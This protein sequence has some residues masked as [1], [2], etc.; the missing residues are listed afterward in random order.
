MIN[1]NNLGLKIKTRHGFETFK[2]IQKLEKG[3]WL[4]LHLEGR[5]IEVTPNHRLMTTEGWKECG[6]MII[7]DILKTDDYFEEVTHIEKFESDKD[8]YDILETESH[9]FI[10][11][12]IV[13][14]NCRFQGSSG[15]LIPSN[16]LETLEWTNPIN[17]DDYLSIYEEPKINNR[18]VAIADPAGGFGLDY[19]VC[20]IIDV[21]D[22]PYK[23]VAKYRNNEISP[24]IF[25]HTI[26]NMCMTYNNCPALVEANNDVGG[27]VTYIL[28]YELEYEN[29][30][31]TSSSQRSIGEI[32][33][34]GK[35][36]TTVPG[37]KT[38]KKVKSVGCSNLKA[39]LENQYL[40]IPDQ[41]MIEELGTFVI[42]GSGYEADEDC[43]DDTVMTLILFSWF[44]KQEFFNDY[45]SSNLGSDIYD[46][47]V[48]RA[49]EDVLPFGHISTSENE[50]QMMSENH[51]ISGERMTV[52]ENLHKSFD[53]W[54]ME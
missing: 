36:S 31:L 40:L 22:Y 44:V 7:G 10:V 34:G 5:T 49:M 16:I 39:L 3:V 23:I 41:D 6:D 30:V 15:T 13:S 8:V 32:R 52:T 43:Y 45:T 26:M 42:K 14:H 33:V 48:K 11:N 46:R 28:Y 9:E 35:G 24:M 50:T 25:P 27:Q 21:T 29:V 37:V 2:G 38:T 18:Y 53:E 1:L 4:K 54:M 20:T 51:F 12:G 47:S 19:S 17:E